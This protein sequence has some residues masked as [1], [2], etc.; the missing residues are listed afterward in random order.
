MALDLKQLKQEIIEQYFEDDGNIPW[1]IGFSGGKDSTMLLQLVWQALMTQPAGL[2]TRQIYVVC[3]N[4]LVENPKIIKY[5]NTVLQLLEKAAMVQSMPVYV[6]KTTPLLEDTFWVNLLGK[7]YPAPNNTFRWCTDRLKI[8]PTSEFIKST[9]SEVGQAIILLGTR[10]DESNSRAR[11]IEKN[12]SQ[13][14]SSRLRK[15]PLPNA[16]V[17]APITDVTTKEVWQYLLQNPSPWGA[18]NRNLVT[19]Y[20]NA[21]GGDCPLI[22]DISTPSCGNSRFGC[23]VCTVVKKDSSMQ[24]LIDNGEEWMEPMMQFRDMLA[25]TRNDADGRETTRRNG[26]E[27]IGAYTEKKRADMLEMLLEAQ[28]EIRIKEPE[29]MLINYQELIAIQ[30]TW[31]RDGYFKYSVAAIYNKVYG[32]DLRDYDFTGNV[33]ENDILNDVCEP[34]DVALINELLELQKSKFILVNNYGMQNDIE[35]HIDRFIKKTQL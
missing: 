20:N 25:E 2:R 14:E 30:V 12:K 35:S 16:Y 22:T 18:S 13:V 29:M 33:E 5:T 11:S 3:N 9:I 23:W 24:A 27:G 28:K 6:K 34:N 1:I 26:A 7:G 19:I 31:N 32:T 8:N 4:T 17:Y 21:T 10:K 15:H